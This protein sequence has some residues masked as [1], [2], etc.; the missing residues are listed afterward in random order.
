MTEVTSVKIDDSALVI[1]S[2]QGD[3]SAMESLILRYQ[4][5]IYNVIL[6]MCSNSHDALELTQ[7]TF[8]KVIE[9]IDRFEQR[10]SFYTWVFRI[11][12]N[13]TLNYCKKRVKL[14]FRSLDSQADAVGGH[15]DLILKDALF[16][17]KAV[18]PEVM[19]QC[20]ELQSLILGAIMKLDEDHRAVIV[21]RDIEGMDYGSIATVL[22]IELGTVK[23]RISR[24][25][26]NLRDILKAVVQ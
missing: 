24:A 23:S 16:N 7:E 9:N 4:D 25:R 26:A 14:G 17:K 8:V 20:H 2:Q 15:E 21:L 6:K 5:R 11:A 13:L 3:S 10:S 18:D 22:E 19:A 12:V 1:R